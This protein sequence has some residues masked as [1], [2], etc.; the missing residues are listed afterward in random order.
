MSFH[1]LLYQNGF[2][3]ELLKRATTKAA[4][5]RQD[6]KGEHADKDEEQGNR[7][8]GRLA[9]NVFRRTILTH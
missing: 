8:N 3:I 9:R 2:A 6:K 7:Q 1:L 4:T 5:A